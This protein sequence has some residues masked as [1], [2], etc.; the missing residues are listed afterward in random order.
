MGDLDHGAGLFPA[1]L[2]HWRGQ[3]GLSQL[4]L[5]LAA[6]VSSRHVSFL[7]TGRSRPSAEMVVRLGATLG[8][9]L[10]HVNAMLAAAG[11]D[12]AYPDDRRAV[13]PSVRQALDLMHAHH[14]PHPLVVLDGA[15]TVRELNGGATALLGL[16]LGGTDALQA[17]LDDGLNLARLTFD[18]AGAHPFLVNADDVGRELLWRLQREVLA[19]PDDG[20]LRGVLDDVLALGTVDPAWRDVDLSVAADPTVVVHLRAGEVDLRFVTTVTA[21]QAPQN[22]AVEDLAIEA[23]YPADDTTTAAMTDL[24]APGSQGLR[25]ST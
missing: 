2:K 5:A 4:D 10:R 7:E 11:H 25:A 21:F 1:L 24:V 8:V 20:A 15:Y 13:P 3:R 6:D 17:R 16:L 12:P 19:D 23:W 22:A 18:P 14:E 9:P